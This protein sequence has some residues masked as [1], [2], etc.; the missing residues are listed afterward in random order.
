MKPVLRCNKITVE[1]G[2]KRVLDSVGFSLLNGE[3]LCVIGPNGAGKS[4]LLRSVLGLISF[5]GSVAVGTTSKSPS[6]KDIS[7]VA[8]S[9]VIPMDMTLAEYVLLGRNPHIG[10]FG[11]ESQK[12][13]EVV[14]SVIEKLSLGEFRDRKM[15]SLSGGETQRGIIARALAQQAPVMILDEPTSALD[16]GHVDT[17]LERLDQLRA[18]E[19]LSLLSVMHDL[20]TAARYADRLLLLDEGQIAAC[21][22]PDEVLDAELLSRVYKKKLNVHLIDGERFIAPARNGK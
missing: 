11:S 10:W 8:Q 17:V 20:S 6:A 4:T 5:S 9:P 12:D 1:Y 22:S 13:L 18:S 21:G 3:W 19:G 7:Y 2:P 16:I 14:E 15:G